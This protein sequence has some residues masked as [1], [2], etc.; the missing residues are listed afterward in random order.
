MTID[1]L[2][3]KRMQLEDLIEN[4]LMTFE[5]EVQMEI[6]KVQIIIRPTANFVKRE[7]KVKLNMEL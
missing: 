3:T 2:R 7:F 6:S 1:E 5:E 4:L